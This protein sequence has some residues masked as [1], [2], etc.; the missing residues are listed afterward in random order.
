[1]SVK[2]NIVILLLR[3]NYFFG[4]FFLVHFNIQSNNCVTY[5]KLPN[6]F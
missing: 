4:V 1:M 2:G 6:D 5:E 3:I